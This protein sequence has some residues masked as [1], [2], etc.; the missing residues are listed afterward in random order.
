[1]FYDACHSENTPVI[2]AL[3]D[4]RVENHKYLSSFI[5]C[6]LSITISQARVDVY[7][8]AYIVKA[9][10]MTA[11]MNLNHVFQFFLLMDTYWILPRFGTRDYSETINRS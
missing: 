5:Y 4:R 1:M 9:N 10:L 7:A 6:Q 2:K 3:V 11:Y 8:Y